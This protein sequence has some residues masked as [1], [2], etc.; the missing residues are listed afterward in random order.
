MK[1]Y[2]RKWNLS[3]VCGILFQL[4]CL[5]LAFSQTDKKPATPTNF[6]KTTA[7]YNA[8]LKTGDLAKLNFFFNLMPKGGDIHHHYSGA[9]YVETYLDWADKS[10]LFIDTITLRTVP[11][12]TK[13]AV[14]VGDLR[15]DDKHYRMLL[16][17][18]S[19]ADF[20]NHYRLEVPPDQQF[21][22]TFSY[23]GNLCAP[24]YKEGFALL[25]KRA[26]LEN[27]QYL[28]TQLSGVTISLPDKVKTQL[29]ANDA[30][31]LELQQTRDEQQLYDL[32]NRLIQMMPVDSVN[33]AVNHYNTALNAAKVG[34]DDSTFT[35]RYQT[36]AYR[37]TTPTNVF[38]AIYGAF[39]AAQSNPYV[40]GVNLVGAENGF[41]SMRDYWL[42]MQMFKY[43]RSIP[44]NSNIKIALHAGELALGMVKPEDLTYHIHD[45]LMIGGA[46][47][48]GH[49]ID[50]T[51]EEFA[52]PVLTYMA[53]SK[54]AVEI[55]LTSNEFILGVKDGLHP[56][57][58]YYDNGV[59]LVISTDD[60]GVSRNNLTNEY[61]LLASRYQ[62][63]YA[64]IKELVANSITY[65]F[66][67]EELKKIQLTELNKRFLNFEKKIG[68]LR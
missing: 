2:A 28:E 31:L 5:P 53:K 59:P 45:A 57:R 19:D 10:G 15:L 67:P 32:F 12:K 64:Q 38:T 35:M 50:I 23:F 24:Y 36:Y 30:L 49:G 8:A 54:K 48:I 21:F 41:Y 34:I 20:Y 9:Q 27:V 16:S 11:T 6:S 68:G 25:K 63:S 18:W 58:L 56:I 17:T 42:H 46:D 37:N 44:A 61:M 51:F 33:A 52:I 29:K 62:F 7:Y 26:Q 60:E 14:T 55:N 65:S 66:M 4:A 47:R 22:N 39:M 13:T 3:L 40:V 43:F 1:N